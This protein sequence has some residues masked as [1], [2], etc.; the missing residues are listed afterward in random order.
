MNFTKK[1]YSIPSL[2]F[3]KARAKKML[4]VLFL[5]SY[6]SAHFYAPLAGALKDCENIEI[7]QYPTFPFD[8]KKKVR[9][10]YDS[11]K[12]WEDLHHNL[13]GSRAEVEDKIVTGYFDLVILADDGAHLF[14]KF[15]SFQARMK[16]WKEW[17]VRRIKG[18]KRLAE[19]HLHYETSM[20]FSLEELARRVCLVAIENCDAACL[21]P[22][23]LKIF[24]VSA[25]Y[26]KREL[27]YDRFFMYYPNRPA[28]W[29]K[30]R[31]KLLPQFK[32]VYG[33]SMGIEDQKYFDLKNRRNSIQDIDVLISGVYSH[34][35]R[36][37]AV[38]RLR[39]MQ[40]T[41]CL[42]IVIADSM[43]FDDY[44]NVVARSKVTL[45][46]AGSRWECFRHFEA[47]A[48]GSIPLMNRPTIDA[49][50]WDN[51]PD[52][53]FFENNFNNFET[54]IKQL[55]VL[56]G[57]RE[58]ILRNLEELIETNML[59]SKIIDFIINTSQ[60]RLL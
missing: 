40:K 38:D 39:D 26:F 53:V 28:P 4:K 31:E 23:N 46:I 1:C 10:L 58:R 25:L 60:S 50:N 56:D 59:S 48:L 6:N 7:F 42:K 21:M 54:R 43:P 37:E 57:S 17:A 12:A 11:K 24:E 22:G 8:Q 18:E 27:P 15:D 3:P 33:L 52:Q 5:R 2:K 47:V 16:T 14:R 19:A 41:S 36:K 55:T 30:W 9:K 32:K 51:A 29:K 35:A 34:T 49:V 45:S 20:P 13:I 44:C